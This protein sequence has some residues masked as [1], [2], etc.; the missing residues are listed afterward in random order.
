MSFKAKLITFVIGI[1]LFS[2]FIASIILKY[3]SDLI[4]PFAT[5][6][7]GWIT[8]FIIWWQGSLLKQQIQFQTYL[9]LEKEWNS[10]EMIKVREEIARS[11][12]DSSQLYKLETILEFMEKFSLF[13]KRNAMD[14]EFI[15][16]SSIGWYAVRYY[17]YNRENIEFLRKEYLDNE[18]YVELRD[19]YNDYLKYEGIKTPD[20]IKIFE[21]D[22]QKTKDKFFENEAK[23]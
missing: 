10:E 13:K 6:L 3:W 4:T 5:L 8:F 2:L 21:E 22:L 16:C 20:K 1:I 14:M 19:L 17:Y 12:S 11:K 18:L 7:V 23:N 15:L 9:E